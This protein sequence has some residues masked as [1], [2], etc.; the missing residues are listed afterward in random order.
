MKRL[1]RRWVTLTRFNDH[2][3]ASWIENLSSEGVFVGCPT[4]VENGVQVLGNLVSRQGDW[5]VRLGMSV[6][7]SESFSVLSTYIVTKVDTDITLRVCI[8]AKN[9]IAWV[10]FM[11]KS[12]P[13]H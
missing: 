10:V 7:L 2:I 12:R 13:S 4:C 9:Q 3:K 11:R 6:T 5:F 8:A 1:A